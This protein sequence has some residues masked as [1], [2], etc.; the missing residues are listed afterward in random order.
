VLSIVDREEGA[1]EMFEDL[2]IPFESLV[3]RSHITEM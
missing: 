1:Q 2:G 3:L